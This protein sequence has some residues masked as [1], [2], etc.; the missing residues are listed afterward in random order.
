MTD[1]NLLRWYRDALIRRVGES[2]ILKQDEI[3]LEIGI[4]EREVLKRMS[5]AA[6]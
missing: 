5:K 2:S 4:V 6:K 3:D 1:E